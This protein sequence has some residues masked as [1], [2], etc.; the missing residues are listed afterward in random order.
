MSRDMPKPYIRASDVGTFLYCRRAW[1][2]SQQD[3]PS[4]LEPERIK[5]SAFHLQHGDRVRAAT[6]AAALA[7]W[8]AMAALALFVVWL[9]MVTR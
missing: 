9:W 6:R 8:C 4:V 7:R 1:Y 2:L 5:G 3:V